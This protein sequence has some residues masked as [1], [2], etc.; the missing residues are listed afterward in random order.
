MH[1]KLH[2]FLKRIQ[3]PKFIKYIFVSVTTQIRWDFGINQKRN[4]DSAEHF[5]TIINK[6]Q[7]HNLILWLMMLTI[8]LS[9]QTKA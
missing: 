2:A 6:Q 7:E 3:T 9:K 1:D 4:W 8:S 5:S